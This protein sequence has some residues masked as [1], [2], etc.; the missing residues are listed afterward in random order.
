VVEGWKKLLPQLDG[1]RP[2]MRV[3]HWFD[4]RLYVEPEGMQAC[5]HADGIRLWRSLSGFAFPPRAGS[6]EAPQFQDRNQWCFN[7]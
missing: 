1:L 5:V 7:V 4:G 3:V 2:V 6:F